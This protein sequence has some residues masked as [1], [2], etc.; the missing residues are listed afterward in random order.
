[1]AEK[2][3]LFFLTVRAHPNDYL[4]FEDFLLIILDYFKDKK[5]LWS[6]EKD[7]TPDRHLHIL[8][9]SHEK[10]AEALYR[11]LNTKTFKAIKERINNES[12]TCWKNHVDGFINL[13]KVKSEEESKTIGY[14]FKEE[15][16]KRC[17]KFDYSE[18]KIL[19]CVKVY[20]ASKRA[21][22]SNKNP[23]ADSIKLLTGRNAHAN[24]LNYCERNSIR[25]DDNT[26]YYKMVR[27]G[28]SFANV[29]KKVMSDIFR[30]I[31]VYKNCEYLNDELNMNC[32]YLSENPHDVTDEIFT[33]L[34]KV[35]SEFPESPLAIALK[36]KY[37]YGLT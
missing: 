33:D 24:I 7:D 11:K 1:M 28:F 13:K 19:D 9:W 23:Y 21:E 27:D 25:Y 31:R 4:I 3:N 29:G 5:R 15:K 30:E 6:I 34:F 8:I 2:L 37:Q 17:F 35:L 20:Y 36:E 18:E 16:I 32:E 14:I 26:I 22:E 12:N 10:D